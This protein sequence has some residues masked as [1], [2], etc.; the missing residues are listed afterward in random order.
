MVSA[1]IV[2]GGRGERMQD[3]L[4]KQ[5]ISV[6]GKP[7]LGHTL[8]VFD[9]CDHIDRIVLVVPKGDVD[10]CQ[11]TVISSLQLHKTIQLVEG[12]TERSDSVYHGL[13]AVDAKTDIVVIHDGVRPF[14]QP[15]Q[16]NECI[17]GAKKTGACI[18]G[19]QIHDTIKR[20]DTSDIIMGTLDREKAYL[21]QTPQAFHRDLIVNAYTHARNDGFIGNDDAQLVERLGQKVKIIKGSRLNIK[22]TEKEDLAFAEMLLNNTVTTDS[23]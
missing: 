21:A 3:S 14:V 23:F 16:I 4:R 1:I 20:V 7:I 10:Y 15:Y 18:L 17:M 6:S 12:G 9:Q 19:I 13:T 11:K 8:L 5:Y 22:I 2:A